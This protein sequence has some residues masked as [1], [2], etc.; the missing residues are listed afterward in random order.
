[1]KHALLAALLFSIFPAAAQQPAEPMRMSEHREVQSIGTEF[2]GKLLCIRPDGTARTTH[3]LGNF[4]TRIEFKGLAIREILKFPV[5]AE[6]LE[7]G[8]T[9]RF[10]AKLACEAHRIWDGPMVVWS[11]WRESNYGFL[12]GKIVIE[13]A[14]GRLQAVT[15]R[16]KSFSP[17]IDGAMTASTH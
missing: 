16:F 15:G 12:P 6:D 13:E 2:L 4:A 5:S 14:G 1:M 8:I 3:Q 10:H 17:G 11:E 9:R 7:K